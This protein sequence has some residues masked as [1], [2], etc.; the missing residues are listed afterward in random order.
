MYPLLKDQDDDKGNLIP[1]ITNQDQAMK[2]LTASAV[3]I[4][5]SVV[6]GA[7]TG[8]NNYYYLSTYC[9]IHTFYNKGKSLVSVSFKSITSSS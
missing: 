2:Q 1:G 9:I 7:I 3:T 6:G 5:I 4:A 8:M